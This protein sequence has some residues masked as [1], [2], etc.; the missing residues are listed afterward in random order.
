MA[1]H[2]IVKCHR[3]DFNESNLTEFKNKSN[4]TLFFEHNQ[5]VLLFFQTLTVSFSTPNL[6]NLPHNECVFS[7]TSGRFKAAT[8]PRGSWRV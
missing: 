7:L 8:G 4:V 3:I 6:Y 1:E 2:V 5:F